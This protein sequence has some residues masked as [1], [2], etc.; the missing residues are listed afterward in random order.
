ME[1]AGDFGERIKGFEEVKGDERVMGWEES[2]RNREFVRVSEGL[3]NAQGTARAV[4]SVP[5]EV[6]PSPSSSLLR[7]IAVSSQ[8]GD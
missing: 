3:L 6:S 8:G 7:Q 1:N 4:E 2:G 5:D